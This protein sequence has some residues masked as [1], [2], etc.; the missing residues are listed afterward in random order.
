M[1]DRITAVSMLHV[2]EGTPVGIVLSGVEEAAVWLHEMFSTR[3]ILST[4]RFCYGMFSREGVLFR[5]MFSS[6]DVLSTRG[7]RGM[8][9]LWDVLSTRSFRHGTFSSMSCLLYETFYSWDVFYPAD[10]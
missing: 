5:R 2:E 8:F 10:G 4:R 1:R 3:E 7:S 6:W 9:P